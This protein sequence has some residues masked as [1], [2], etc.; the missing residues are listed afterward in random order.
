MHIEDWLPK[1]ILG[2]TPWAMLEAYFETNASYTKTNKV[3]G[4]SSLKVYQGLPRNAL[5]ELRVLK[6]VLNAA[7]EVICDDSYGYLA[8]VYGGLTDLQASTDLNSVLNFFC[9]FALSLK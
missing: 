4:V 5:P 1:R 6:S 9:T 8:H 2:C 3:V 7:N